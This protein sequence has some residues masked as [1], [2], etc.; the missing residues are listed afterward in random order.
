MCFHHLSRQIHD[1]IYVLESNFI[2]RGFQESCHV[3]FMLY[4]CIKLFTKFLRASIDFH[5][6]IRNLKKAS[7]SPSWNIFEHHHW[8]IFDNQNLR[9]PHLTFIP[10]QS[11]SKLDCRNLSKWKYIQ[12]FKT[13][14]F[15]CLSLQTSC[16][17]QDKYQPV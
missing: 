12:E 15:A 3:V 9:C 5:C 4:L 2:Y 6:K 16:N 10:L 1:L 11:Y 8:S 17:D 7:S 14:F 13:P